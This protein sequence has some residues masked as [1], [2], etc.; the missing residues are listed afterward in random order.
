M[1]YVSSKKA[2][3][4][5]R[6]TIGK[7]MQIKTVPVFKYGVTDTKDGVEEIVSFE[8]IV[9]YCEAGVDIKGVRKIQNK[10]HKNMISY[11]ID[12][13]NAETQAR[14]DFEADSEEDE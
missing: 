4:E 1:F 12:V 8:D 6:Q 9:R 2:T 7:D 3:G 13:Y 14:M 10:K 5:K 11:R